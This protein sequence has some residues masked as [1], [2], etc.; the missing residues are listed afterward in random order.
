MSN[1]FNCFCLFVN[2][3]RRNVV[4]LLFKLISFAM[5]FLQQINEQRKAREVEQVLPL[6]IFSAYADAL[7]GT[8]PR[9]LVK[10]LSNGFGA[11]SVEMEKVSNAIET[12]FPFQLAVK[13]VD[14][15]S[16][17]FKDFLSEL[18]ALQEGLAYSNASGLKKLAAEIL[19]HHRSQ[20]KHHS[21][22]SGLGGLLFVAFGAVMPAL[23]ASISLLG[24]VIG[25]SLTA[26]EVFVVFLLVFPLV[27]ALVLVYLDYTAPKVIV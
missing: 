27:N 16:V 19:S 20:L 10:N 9:K 8:E 6:A 18:S 26:M 22:K 7:T 3:Q 17:Y 24:S 2:L 13:K 12:G 15:K 11:L 23:F 25:F 1:F 21:S 4:K 14:S 5:Q